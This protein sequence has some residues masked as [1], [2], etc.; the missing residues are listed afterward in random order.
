MASGPAAPDRRLVA[1]G[2]R[3]RARRRDLSLTLKALAERSGLSERFLVSLEG[4]HANVSVVKLYD[5]AAAL[6][7][8]VLALLGGS[9]GVHTAP[10]EGDVGLVSLLGLRGA[11]KTTI[12]GLAATRLGVPFV[13][14]DAL[15]SARTGLSLAPLF[16]LQGTEGYRKLEREELLGLLA[17]SP[18]AVIATGGGIVTDAQSFELLRAR[19][20]TIWLKA[21]PDDHWNRVLAQGDGRPM[22]NRD[23]AMEE[24]RHLWLARRALYE[25]AAHVVDTSSLGI[26]RAVE[27]VVKIARSVRRLRRLQLGPTKLPSP[28]RRPRTPPR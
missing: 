7:V 20:V 25:R 14:L 17:T 23:A 13:E 27:R 4:G 10:E 15:V 11:G 16:E 3:V 9:E 21:S 26:E 18:R 28:R 6:D 22:A 2:E 1:L 5:L 19:T 8:D 24:L 12:G